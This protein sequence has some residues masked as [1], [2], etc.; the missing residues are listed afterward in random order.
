[1]SYSS[2]FG[3]TD[4]TNLIPAVPAPTAGIRQT[5]TPGTTAAPMMLFTPD[6]S[7][8]DAGRAL[9]TPPAPHRAA[10]TEAKRAAD[11][12]RPTSIVSADCADYQY[13][14][15]YVP[16]PRTGV[17]RAGTP[18]VAGKKITWDP[19]IVG[20][21]FPQ[22][23]VAWRNGNAGD[24]QVR[25]G[26]TRATAAFLIGFSSLGPTEA[27]LYVGAVSSVDV[28]AEK[29]QDFLAG[30]LRTLKRVE[31]PTMGLVAYAVVP[32]Q[33]GPPP[34]A[35]AREVSYPAR[36]GPKYSV[37]VARQVAVS[38]AIAK[39]EALVAM[40]SGEI[41]GGL[42]V[43]SSQDLVIPGEREVLAAV[44][45]IGGVA[46]LAEL[47]AAVTSATAALL[48]EAEAAKQMTPEEGDK[49]VASVLERLAATQTAVANDLGGRVS[50][51]AAGLAALPGAQAAAGTYAGN[52]SRTETE[53]KRLVE[54]K[55]AAVEARPAFTS[56]SPGEKHAVHCIMLM[57][58]A[59]L[60]ASRTATAQPRVDALVA[61][62]PADFAAAVT[63]A[64]TAYTQAQ[65]AAAA[66]FADAIAR[67]EAIR[68]QIALDWYMRSWNGLPVWAW[69]AGGAALLIGGVVVVRVMRKKKSA[70]AVTK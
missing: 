55:I 61:I 31:P 4:K 16:L 7:A 52:A 36:I 53:V 35:R 5:S 30:M 1:M 12:E 8:A 67:A 47:P 38:A 48:A 2:V 70:A 49:A 40:I 32:A 25:V 13:M 28:L 60:V 45:A 57:K 22:S 29:M 42:A 66:V 41:F 68:K 6:M 14:V 50:A 27:V 54:T 62:S 64:A 23:W 44:A 58:A 17:I 46:A 39:R 10:P 59:P 9:S 20:A 19:A 15:S 3:A 26:L 11:A 33:A 63:S 69:G 43:R 65:G 51:L 21:G 56:L 34:I 18:V 24:E 37:D